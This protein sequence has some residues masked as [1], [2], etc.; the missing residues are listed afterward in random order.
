MLVCVTIEYVDCALREELCGRRRRVSS[1]WFFFFH[2]A[3]EGCVGVDVQLL[4]VATSGY[5]ENCFEV[6]VE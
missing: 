5:A 1:L 2:V 4:L 6:V 3:G